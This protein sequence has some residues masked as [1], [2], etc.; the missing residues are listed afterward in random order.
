VQIQLNVSV[1]TKVLL[2]GILSIVALSAC[3]TISTA[4]MGELYLSDRT[5]RGLD[6][7]M[8]EFNP[9]IFAASIDGKQYSYYYCDGD[10]CRVSATFQGVL[11]NCNK[12]S[13][14][15]CRVLAAKRQIV[16]TK[17]NGEKYTLE[18]LMDP[19]V[20]KPLS[21]INIDISVLGAAALCEKA[22]APKTK[23]WSKF[24][25]ALPYV[26]EAKQRG[27]SSNFCAKMA[28]TTH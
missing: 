7:Y 10:K 8:N 3:K 27:F 23:Q 28:S 18:D 20:K 15:P 5:K 19:S 2:A 17:S 22:Y 24:A 14:T 26:T 11:D 1:V 25:L 9:M 16:W 21:R 12:H 6:A 4:G 13:K